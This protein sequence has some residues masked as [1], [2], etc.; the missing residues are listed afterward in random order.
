VKK[1]AVSFEETAVF[2]LNLGLVN[3]RHNQ[4]F[5][6]SPT[7]TNPAMAIFMLVTA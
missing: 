4:S 1:T 3:S 2:V 7:L 5:P 6:G